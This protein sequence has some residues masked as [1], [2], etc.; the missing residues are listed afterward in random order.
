MRVMK[1]G[2]TEEGYDVIFDRL[3]DLGSIVSVTADVVA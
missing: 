2:V 3:G 1:M